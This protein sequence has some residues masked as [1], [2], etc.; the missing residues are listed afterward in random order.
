MLDEE[1]DATARYERFVKA[2]EEAAQKVLTPVPKRNKANLY[3]NDPRVV[4]AR[5]EM[6]YAYAN[7]VP[8]GKHDV[9]VYVR[10]KEQLFK[11]YDEAMAEDLA[12]KSKAID[13]THTNNNSSK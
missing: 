11:V 13:D 7:F 1:E 4:K 8:E 12:S 6:E 9:G 3:S 5:Q 2:H 10:K